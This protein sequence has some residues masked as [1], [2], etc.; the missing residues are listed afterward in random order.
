MV[1]FAGWSQLGLWGNTDGNSISRAFGC[2]NP[3]LPSSEFIEWLVAL[4]D[5]YKIGGDGFGTSL[6]HGGADR[7]ESGEAGGDVHAHMHQFIGGSMGT[8]ANPSDPLFLVSHLM[9]D[10]VFERWLRQEEASGLY[11]LDNSLPAGAD[12]KL[13]GAGRARDECQNGLFP[14][15]KQGYYF[16]SGQ[17]FGFTYDYF[18]T[19]EI[20]TSAIKDKNQ[21]HSKKSASHQKSHK[22]ESK[23]LATSES[24]HR[25]QP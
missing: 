24:S 8:F 11:S 1:P 6:F 2:L 18:L 19:N 20:S 4:P 16:R 7:I 3:S 22:V 15:N 5:Y 9:V 12:A 17:E 25:L 14:L 21:V 13:V 23:K 10:L